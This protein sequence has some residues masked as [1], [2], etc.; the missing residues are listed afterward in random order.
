MNKIIIFLI[1]NSVFIASCFAEQSYVG[2]SIGDSKVSSDNDN[3]PIAY[4]VFLGTHVNDSL[5]FEIGIINL[6]NFERT[7]VT[8][9][10]GGTELSAVGS[11]PLGKDGNLFGKLGVFN[12]NIESKV[13]AITSNSDGTDITIGLGV[14]LPIK[15][16]ILI[17][18][19]YQEFR[20]IDTADDDFTFLSVGIGLSF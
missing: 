15:D 14:Q 5:G 18:I 13:G 3:K 10:V 9:K 16:N 7:G 11:I 8:S 2:A 17:R 4:K 12:W 20:D 19:E 6:G 1:L